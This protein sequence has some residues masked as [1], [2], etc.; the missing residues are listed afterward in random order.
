[1]TCKLAILDIDGTIAEPGNRIRPRVKAAMR[2][3]Q[4]RGVPVCL[5]TGRNLAHTLPI[6]DA[7]D[8]DLPFSTVDSAFIY[9]GRSG[10][11]LFRN[12]LPPAIQEG[13]L[14]IAARHNVYIEAVTDTHYNKLLRGT[15]AFDYGDCNGTPLVRYAEDCQDLL[16]LPPDIGEFIFGGAAA[17]ISSL[18]GAIAA[19][20]G[21]AVSLRDDLW[22]GYLF[23]GLRGL[24][25]TLGLRLLCRHFGVD[26]A[27]ACAIGDGLN[28]L[29][30]LAL[31][32][33]GVAM[34][35]ADDR[36]KTAADYITNTIQAD[37]A[38]L[39]LEKFFGEV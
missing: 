1:M 31:A 18:R 25:K 15:A 6:L 34:G 5:S 14:G 30:F 33:T 2:A 12:V 37:G 26:V 7:L 10:G 4:A 3:L 16:H 23:A 35:N 13:I 27:E 36:T 8:M 38:A 20:Y 32:G 39:A 9:E 17:D 11:I 29:D 24:N 22:E 28:D 21:D 19:A